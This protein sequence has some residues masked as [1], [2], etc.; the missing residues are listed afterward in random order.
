[1]IT[2]KS[3]VRWPTTITVHKYPTTLREEFGYVYEFV[4]LIFISNLTWSFPGHGL[5][6]HLAV[7]FS[8]FPLLPLSFQ[9]PCSLLANNI[10]FSSKVGLGARF[11]FSAGG[12]AAMAFSAG[13]LEGIGAFEASAL[14]I[15]ISL[16]ESYGL[17]W[18][19]S[20]ATQPTAVY[21]S[22]AMQLS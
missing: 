16:T 18:D 19:I 15:F 17:R 3:L 22:E 5:V 1:M 7:A 12:N 21:L 11:F 8:R 6:S 9:Q 20:E 14:F 13:M 2:S 10:L 4:R